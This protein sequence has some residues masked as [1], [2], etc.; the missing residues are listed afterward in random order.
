[1]QVEAALQLHTFTQSH[2]MVTSQYLEELYHKNGCH[3]VQ[4]SYA[5]G[6]FKLLRT[7]WQV[8]DWLLEGSIPEHG[9]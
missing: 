9:K 4:A 1:M 6:L 7:T 8:K 2:F 5:S 3:S